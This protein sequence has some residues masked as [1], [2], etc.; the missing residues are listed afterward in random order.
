MQLYQNHGTALSVLTDYLFENE[1]KHFLEEPTSNHIFIY[2]VDGL[3]SLL[4]KDEYVELDKDAGEII[5]ENDF[6]DNRLDVQFQ[7]VDNKCLITIN[8]NY[9]ESVSTNAQEEQHGDSVNARDLRV[10]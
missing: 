9:N 1:Q 10:S 6:I 8:G 7:Y 3:L 4:N 2:V 5:E